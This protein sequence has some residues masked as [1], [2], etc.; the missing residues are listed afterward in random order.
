L[1]SDTSDSSSSSVIQGIL[2]ASFDK[3]NPVPECGIGHLEA[4]QDSPKPDTSLKL[5]KTWTIKTP[6]PW[7]LQIHLPLLEQRLL[8]HVQPRTNDLGVDVRDARNEDRNVMN[9][10]L[11]VEGVKQ[12][13]RNV[14]MRLS[15]D[16]EAE[17][18]INLDSVLVCLRLR[19]LK[20]R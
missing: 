20:I 6:K 17:H 1:V 9:R 4:L 16:G 18:L 15:F 10:D 13:M 12:L 7:L 8:Q 2:T 3:T 5:P 11:V 14:L 19:Y